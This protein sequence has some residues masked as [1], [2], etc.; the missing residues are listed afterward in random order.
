M[1]DFGS[2]RIRAEHTGAFETPIIYS[3]FQDCNALCDA[4]KASIAERRATAENMPRSNVGGWHS[5]TKM[6]DWGGEAAGFV[7]EKALALA[8]RITGLDKGDPAQLDW[9]IYMWA[10]VLPSG[11]LNTAHVHPAQLW[12]AVFYVDQGDVGEDLGGELVLEDPRF[13]MTHMR[14]NSLRVLGLDGNPQN[15]EM[16]LRP[17]SGDLVLFPAW[18]RHS[19]RPYHGERERISLAMNIDARM[20]GN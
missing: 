15:G 5:D 12:A 11:G 14:M 2:I 20:P 8:K 16:R 19:V 9:S 4:L 18:L 1:S 13:P 6:L 3:R 7:A 10:N 17:N